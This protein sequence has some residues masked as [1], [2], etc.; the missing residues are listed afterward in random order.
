MRARIRTRWDRPP[1][2]RSG[3][4][5]H[6]PVPT[7]QKPLPR[8]AE[9][10]SA[11]EP[12]T[13]SLIR[14]VAQRSHPAHGS[15]QTAVSGASSCA[16]C[17]GPHPISPRHAREDRKGIRLGSRSRS[18]VASPPSGHS[19][20]RFGPVRPAVCRRRRWRRIPRRREHPAGVGLRPS[21]PS[22]WNRTGGDRGRAIV[23]R[24]P[25]AWRAARPGGG[26]S[27]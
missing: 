22:W 1:A 13:L 3:Q 19:A 25:G 8:S 27:R 6:W 11:G 18:S 14:W 5:Y 21:R 20:G 16:R 2:I 17:S 12:R 23:A 9:T 10:L 26:T 4:E 7:V 15:T 24:R